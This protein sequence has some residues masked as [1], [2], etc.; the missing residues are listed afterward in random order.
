M[1]LASHSYTSYLSKPKAHSRAGVHFFLTDEN[2]DTELNNGDI[3]NVAQ[4]IKTIMSSAA[5]A[6]LGPLFINTKLVVPIQ[7]TLEE[8]GHPQGHTPMQTDNSTVTVNRVVNGKIQPKQTKA[9]GVQFYWLKDREAQNIFDF[10][11]KW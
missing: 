7:Y 2:N 8:L 3:L 4:I 1:K 6:E 11:Q 10:L 9:M 5:E